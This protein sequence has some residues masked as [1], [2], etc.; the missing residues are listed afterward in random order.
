MGESMSQFGSSPK[1][2]EYYGEL[3]FEVLPCIVYI[4]I[5]ICK[6]AGKVILF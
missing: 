2:I 6:F 3:F 1:E 5:I 4:I